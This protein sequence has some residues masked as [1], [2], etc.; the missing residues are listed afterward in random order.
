[1]GADRADQEVGQFLFLR[2][3]RTD[4]DV[5]EPQHLLLGLPEGNAFGVGDLDDGVNLVGDVLGEDYLA[6]VMEQ[7][8]GVGLGWDG[9]VGF[10]ADDLGGL[11]DDERVPE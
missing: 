10:F 2:Q 7:A 3:D 4:L 9:A 1:M 11:G 8:G 5:V 6:D